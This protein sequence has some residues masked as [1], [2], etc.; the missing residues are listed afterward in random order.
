MTAPETVAT[1]APVL[2]WLEIR[3][4]RAF[5]TAPQRLDLDAPLSVLHGS[6][7][8]GKSSLAE[9]LEFLLTGRSSRRDLLGG[10]KAEYH[11]TLRNV[12]LPAADADVWVA[13]GMRGADG[14]VHEVR[15][16]LVC[17]FA[18]G[19][20]CDSR[21]L[22]DGVVKDDLGAFGL[23]PAAGSNL[24]APVL[25]QHTLRHVLSTEPKQRVAY[26]KSLLSLTDLDELRERVAQ[27]RRR[28]RN[29]P[30]TNGGSML[31]ALRATP[32]Q[33]VFVALGFARSTLTEEQVTGLVQGALLTA[34]EQA[35][36]KKPKDLTDLNDGLD[37]MLERQRE[38]AFPLGA[39]AA[40]SVPEDVAPVDI[41]E[42]A[43]AL[44][45]ADRKLAEL[46]PIFNAVLAAPTIQH[47]AGPVDCPVCATPQALT[48]ER[49]EVLR[50]ALRHGQGLEAAAFATLAALRAAIADAGRCSQQAQAAVPAAAHWSGEQVQTAKEQ[51]A[52]LELD[53]ALLITACSAARDVKAAAA[54]VRSTA[55][56]LQETL[57]ADMGAITT[58]VDVNSTASSA[59]AVDLALSMADLRSAQHVSDEAAA[60]LHAA[61]RPV[62]A[63]RTAGAG[64]AELLRAV[65]HA[66]DIAVELRSAAARA[67][68]DSRLSAAEGA[69]ATAAV[70]IL[71]SRFQ[72]MSDSITRWWSTIRP[73]ELVAF[74]GVQRRASGTTFVSLMAAL[75]TD[76]AATP[77]ERHALGVFSDSQLN[78]LG[79]STFL[80]RTE[81]LR[82]PLVVLDDPIPGSDADHRFTFAQNTV[83]AL[84][85]AGAQ[86]ILTTYDHHLAQLTAAQHSGQAHRT[87]E[88]T[89][90]DHVAGT[91][92]TQTSD[93]FDQLMLDA[94]DGVNSPGAKGRRQA[95]LSY[96]AAAE[97]LAKQI[98]ATGRTAQGT[99][100]ALGDVEREAKVLGDLVPLVRGFALDSTEKGNWT[101][102]PKVLN[103]GNHDDEAPS[104]ATLR[105]V[106]GNLKKIARAHKAHW[107]GGL[108]R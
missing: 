2:V 66:G 107:S 12:H 56:A 18:Q 14:Q 81:L 55:S 78:A 19:T 34:G 54:A 96:R 75:R 58:R 32:F 15:R 101:T 60:A 27:V 70:D 42:Y 8:Q 31:T 79:L 9:A 37:S 86:V 97:R 103:P 72:Q 90:T 40:S 68:A 36:G 104:T 7:S 30:P 71:D 39:F 29:Q 3:G 43:A 61:V 24:G 22:V 83:G 82:T 67:A 13:A 93:V 45:R 41:S 1:G 91:E 11:E 64:L 65:Q 84:L 62:V 48:P 77:V 92:A 5:G 59:A 88:L 106:R 63:A 33:D 6:N 49:L 21:L 100:T 44:G 50:D 89:L 57:S 17:D 94:E 35:L 85:A 16:E 102:F 46:A 74:A 108:V 105:V 52:T 4:F 47:A 10:A 25:L 98:I 51:L 99:P 38:A 73:E 23:A 53:E 80:A 87:F 95:S 20:E 69:L 26:F 28:L 76:P